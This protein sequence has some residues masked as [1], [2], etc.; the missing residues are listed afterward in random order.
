M[1]YTTPG[2][3]IGKKTGNLASCRRRPSVARSSQYGGGRCCARWLAGLQTF[4]CRTAA[5]SAHAAGSSLLRRCDAVC[6]WS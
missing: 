5:P 1:R 3:G 2:G 6:A 4:G